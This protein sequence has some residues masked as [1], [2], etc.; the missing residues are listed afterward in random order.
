MAFH[1]HILAVSVGVVAIFVI[2][3]SIKHNFSI[4]RRVLLT[5][6]KE[7]NRVE[8]FYHRITAS[9]IYSDKRLLY[10][11]LKAL[12]LDYGFTRENKKGYKLKKNNYF[13]QNLI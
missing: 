3:I 2:L 13:F 8:A 4:R 5:A 10:N 7:A 6:D 9:D 11:A 1:A 12:N